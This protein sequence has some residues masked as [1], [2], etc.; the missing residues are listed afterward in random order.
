MI[1]IQAYKTQCSKKLRDSVATHLRV[2]SL[3]SLFLMSLL[4]VGTNSTNIPAA[5]Y[6]FVSQ[7]SGFIFFLLVLLCIKN[8]EMIRR[9]LLF[10]VILTLG[11]CLISIVL[12]LNPNLASYLPVMNMFYP[13]YGHNHLAEWLLIVIPIS[14]WLALTEK[15]NIFKIFPFVFTLM[16]WLSFGR[17]ATVL[18]L[19][20]LVVLLLLFR[21][22]NKV[23]LKKKRSIVFFLIIAVFVAILAAGFTVDRANS[24]LCDHI[25]FSKLL[26]KTNE[27]SN[28]LYYW[29][30]SVYL[31]KENPL[32]G[33]GLMNYANQSLKHVQVPGFQSAYAHNAVLQSISEG[34]L[35]A[36]IPFVLLFGY[37]LV[38]VTIL[39]YRSKDHFFYILLLSI[40]SSYACALL[41]FSW[42]FKSI[43]HLTLFLLASILSL[44][45]AQQS[46]FFSKKK[47]Q[48][49]QMINYFVIFGVLVVIVLY[50]VVVSISSIQ[51]SIDSKNPPNELYKYL[52]QYKKQYV[53]H[54]VNAGGDRKQEL[55]EIYGNDQYVLRELI[56][57]S[58]DLDERNHYQS[59]MIDLDPWYALEFFDSDVYSQL[60]SFEETTKKIDTII[61]F[62]SEKKSRYSYSPNYSTLI[63]FSR[64]VLDIADRHYQIGNYQKAGNYYSF[65]QSFDPWILSKRSPIISA[66]PISISQSE[67]ISIISERGLGHY[68]Q[69]QKTYSDFSFELFELSLKEGDYETAI[70]ML[71]EYLQ[72]STSGKWQTWTQVLVKVSEELAAFEN[73]DLYSLLRHLVET[74]GDEVVEYASYEL[75]LRIVRMIQAKISQSNQSILS[76]ENVNA[77]YIMEKLLPNEYWVSAQ[78]GNYYAL[79]DETEKAVVAFDACLARFENQ[80]DDCYYGK[81]GVEVGNFNKNRFYEVS[82]I[83]LGEKRWQ[84]FQ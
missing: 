26:C 58:I 63:N 64:S 55:L 17:I 41:D 37:L 18:G 36:T 67:F 7:I 81:Q 20:Q 62:I 79:V 72:I 74:H 77:I 83:I 59:K 46:T 65:V 21:K 75:R 8:K 4:V 25:H 29:Q 49:Y 11:F 13:T 52:L 68:G 16:L 47:Q 69:N 57:S 2:I 10:V 31:W 12:Y 28:R 71:T 40:Y 53:S 23:D 66:V 54:V 15:R 43:Y 70:K 56:N 5:L 39:V 1:N 73:Q 6:A 60:N 50:N 22:A 76:P 84:D 44:V 51:Q 34:G 19:I 38:K 80:H 27:F 48:V 78:L 14:W 30:Q 42:S 82:Q 32:L 35:V 9:V 3:W 33:S 24:P 61:E 45:R